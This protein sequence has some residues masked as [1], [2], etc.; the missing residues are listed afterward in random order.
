MWLTFL[1]IVPGKNI[2]FYTGSGIDR[3]SS[4]RFV[5]VRCPND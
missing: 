3:G 2:Q 5:A 1:D 4:F